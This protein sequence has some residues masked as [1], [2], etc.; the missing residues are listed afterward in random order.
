MHFGG[1]SCSCHHQVWTPDAGGTEGNAPPSP[2][3]QP[4]EAKEKVLKTCFF[5]YI[6]WS[7]DARK[8]R[9]TLLNGKKFSEEG[10]HTATRDSQV[11]TTKSA[12]PFF[13]ALGKYLTDVLEYTRV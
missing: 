8:L 10:A 11:L 6:F 3:C 5:V 4:K 13:A 9:L 7:P 2:F 1:G 12:R